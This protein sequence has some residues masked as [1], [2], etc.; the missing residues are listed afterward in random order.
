MNF[1][2]HFGYTRPHPFP[3]DGDNVGDP[4]PPDVPVGGGSMSCPKLYPGEQSLHHGTLW[5]L[6]WMVMMPP[7]Q[8]HHNP[9]YE[10]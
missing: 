7:T 6:S 5:V 9:T 2:A 1:C 8:M 10:A 4:D 3:A